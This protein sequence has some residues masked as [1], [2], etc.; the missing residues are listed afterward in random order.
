MEKIKI[1]NPGENWLREFGVFSWPVWTKEPSRFNWTYDGDEQC[2]I[3][4]GEFTVETGN[5]S[6]HIRPGDFVT[7]KKGLK[8]IWDIK[9]AVKKHYN[10]P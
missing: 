1:E 8:C 4:E 6:V 3:L 9:K 2:Y 5:G 7:F 10:F